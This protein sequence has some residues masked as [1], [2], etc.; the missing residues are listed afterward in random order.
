MDT[1]FNQ[2]E[3]IV[4]ALNSLAPQLTAAVTAAGAPVPTVQAAGGQLQGA[5]AKIKTQLQS[6][7]Q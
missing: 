1:M 4:N 3:A 7:K 2:L 5:I 6:M